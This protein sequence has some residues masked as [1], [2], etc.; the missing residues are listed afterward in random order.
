MSD[1]RER[2]RGEGRRERRGR[3]EGAEGRGK[4]R[5]T[6]LL[7]EAEALARRWF[8]LSTRSE[9]LAKEVVERMEEE[10]TGRGKGFVATRVRE[11]G[12]VEEGASLLVSLTTRAEAREAEVVGYGRGLIVFVV[13]GGSKIYQL[14]KVREWK[15]EGWRTL[16]F[17]YFSG[18]L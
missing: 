8:S 17:V 3:E 4:E 14:E 10:V 9:V 12:R 13:A 6:Y 1:G 5:R 7:A 2:R 16:I 11:G 18:R 15:E